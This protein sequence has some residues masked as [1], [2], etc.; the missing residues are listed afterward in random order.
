MSLFVVLEQHGLLDFLGP[1][2]GAAPWH[3]GAIPRELRLDPA[4]AAPTVAD[5][6]PDRERSKE[7]VDLALLRLSKV[8]DAAVHAQRCHLA[9]R[10]QH[11]ELGA[12]DADA[13]HRESPGRLGGRGLRGGLRHD[14]DQPQTADDREKFYHASTVVDFADS[15]KGTV[16]QWV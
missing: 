10:H 6:V 5:D 11:P 1:A 7:R 4:F 3:S 15:R 8:Q 16:A 9:D 14:V 12:A 2:R 13:S